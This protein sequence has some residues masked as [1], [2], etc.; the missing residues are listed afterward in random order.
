MDTSLYTT[1]ELELKV[2]R[3]Q[4]GRVTLPAKMLARVKAEIVRRKASRLAPE[5]NETSNPY[6]VDN[7]QFGAGA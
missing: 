1:A 7:G 5:T 3:H 4:E 6:V 2:L